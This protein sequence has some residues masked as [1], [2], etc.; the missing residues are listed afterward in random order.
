[1]NQTFAGLLGISGFVLLSWAFACLQN[2]SAAVLMLKRFGKMLLPS[3]AYVSLAVVAIIIELASGGQLRFGAVIAGALAIIFSWCGS[4]FMNDIYDIEVDK[5]SAEDRATADGR[6]TT[7]QTTAAAG[8]LG[9]ASIA[10]AVLVSPIAVGATAA[11]IVLN[12]V[13]SIPPFR[14]KRSGIGSMASLGLMGASAVF[15]GSATVSPNPSEMTLRFAVI[16]TVAMVINLSYTDLKDEENDAQAGIVNFV[17]RFGRERVR[18]FHMV[19]L[20]LSYIGS[21]LIL[22]IDH[23]VSLGIVVLLGA[24]ATGL[25]V[26][27]DATKPGLVYRLDAVNSLYLVTI[28]A[29]YYFL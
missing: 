25:L 17:V 28:A 22:R 26:T 10:S 13:Y 29:S 6:L 5:H 27:H 18:R 7:T 16:V 11:M 12:L 20:P 8:L 14:L 3:F 21:A 2:R 1:M 15:V 23:P 9:S 24:T 19:S 4:W